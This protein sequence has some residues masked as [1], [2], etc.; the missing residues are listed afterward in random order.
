MIYY[1]LFKPFLNK[2]IRIDE[3]FRP[4][5]CRRLSLFVVQLACIFAFDFSRLFNI[6]F[7]TTMKNDKVNQFDEIHESPR[8]LF[9]SYTNCCGPAMPPI[10]PW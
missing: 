1:L 10:E 3:G 9:E 5:S 7:R 4:S 6:I 2:D 8:S